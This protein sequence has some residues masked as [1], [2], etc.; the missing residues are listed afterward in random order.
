MNT[1]YNNNV[2]GA[3]KL[4]TVNG[5]L[6]QLGKDASASEGGITKLYNDFELYKAATDGAYDAKTI[7]D[8]IDTLAA[9]VA[10]NATTIT[11]DNTEQYLTI[12]ETEDIS[13]RKTYTLG[14][15][16][17]DSAVSTAIATVV[18][19]APAAFDTLKEIADWILDDTTGASTVIAKKA[20]KVDN[21]TSGNFASLDA[22]GNITDSGHTHTDYKTVQTATTDPTANGNAVAFIDTLTQNAQGV[23]TATKKT[24]T[25]A[26]SAT[27]GLMSAAHY[28][29]IE[30]LATVATSGSYNDLTDAP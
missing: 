29:K 30:S 20:D 14:T 10:A 2:A 21:A 25:S 7:Y 24:V 16:G 26:S 5:S 8:K 22:N 15:T 11:K 17:I 9:S 1:N 6:Y 18:N 19:G 23:I 3:L 12:A 4:I 28:N 27:A 13:G